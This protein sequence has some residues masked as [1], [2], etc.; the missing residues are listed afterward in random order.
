MLRVRHGLYQLMHADGVVHSHVSFGS[1]IEGARG[2]GGN[3]K[4]FLKH[5]VFG[6]KFDRGVVPA[7]QRIEV[8]DCT[9]KT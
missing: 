7:R 4:A 1:P 5:G 2:I 8:Q 3:L 9:W 6:Q